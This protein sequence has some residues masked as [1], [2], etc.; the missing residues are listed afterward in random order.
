MKRI[1][2]PIR[3]DEDYSKYEDYWK[4]FLEV[5]LNSS[6]GLFRIFSWTIQNIQLESIW[7]IAM[8]FGIF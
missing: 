2:F 7:N 4:Y 3:S 8:L 6:A 5:S 1:G